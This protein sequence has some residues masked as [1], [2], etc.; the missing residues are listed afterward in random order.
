MG[1]AC[2]FV[3]DPGAAGQT[4]SIGRSKSRAS[5]QISALADIARIKAAMEMLQHSPRSVQWL[6]ALERLAMTAERVGVAAAEAI[7]PPV[8][9]PAAVELVAQYG[10]AGIGPW[11]STVNLSRMAAELSD[12]EARIRVALAGGAPAVQQP[13]ERRHPRP[14]ALPQPQGLLGRRALEQQRYNGGHSGHRHW[15]CYRG[16]QWYCHDQL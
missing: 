3:P 11:W 5:E 4:I 15:H 13:P 7:G 16:E 9:P 6:M 14:R 12:L 8:G 10:R 2:T 1:S